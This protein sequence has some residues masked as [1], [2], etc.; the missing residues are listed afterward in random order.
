MWWFEFGVTICFCIDLCFNFNTAYL[1]GS[2]WVIDRWMIATNYARTWLVID[3]LSSFPVEI[4]DPRFGLFE[5]GGASD[6]EAHYGV[7]DSAFDPTALRALRMVRLLRMLKLLKVQRIIDELEDAFV[8]SMQLLKI[9]QMV[10]GLVYLMHIL[11]CFW[12]FIASTG[13]HDKTWLTSYDGGSGLTKPTS[14]KYLYS[15]YWALTTL[16]TVG[17]GDIVPTNNTERVYVLCSLL[18]G[19][20][21]FGYMLSAIGEL[22]NTLD[23]NAVVL[24]DKFAEIKDFTRWHRM[25]PDLAARVRKYFDYFYMRKSAMDEEAIVAN[26]APALQR[27]VISYLLEKT[28]AQIPM[29]SIEYCSYA[30]VEFQLEV[31]PLLKPL[32]YEASV[33]HHPSLIVPKRA[34]GADLFFLS[35]GTVA[36]CSSLGERVL[37]PIVAKGSLLGEHILC[38]APAELAYRAATRCELFSLN[39][40]D[41]YA[42]LERRPYARAELAEFVFED[43]LR[44]GMLRYWALRMVVKEIKALDE[45]AGAALLLQVSWVRKLVIRLQDKRLA[46]NGRLEWLMP[47]LF[48]LAEPSQDLGAWPSLASPFEVGPGA[49][50]SGRGGGG[51][52]VATA[53]LAELDSER[54]KLQKRESAIDKQVRELEKMVAQLMVKEQQG[55]PSSRDYSA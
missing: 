13:E 41:L 21:V 10:A 54:Q 1:A 33:P 29:F 28:A 17:F 49:G 2:F 34:R 40:E 8:T 50:S 25:G 6:S 39:K 52:E 7:S 47:G 20:L 44:H 4:F 46:A 42:L 30:T 12:Y 55:L 37:F 3:A 31:H 9:V 36:A 11:G 19:A 32:M 35:K 5:A 18:I 24:D 45:R 27:E 15:V 51:G 26:L 23:K 38:N 14:V 22:V 53:A 48:G 16:T 43:L